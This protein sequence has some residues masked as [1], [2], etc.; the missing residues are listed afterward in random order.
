MHTDVEANA[1]LAACY[2]YD[3]DTPAALQHIEAAIAIAG[4]ESYPEEEISYLKQFRE[5]IQADS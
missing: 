3:G 1:V 2:A 4:A 5:E